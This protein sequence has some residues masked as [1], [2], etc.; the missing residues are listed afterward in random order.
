MSGQG[1]GAH[2]KLDGMLSHTRD[3]GPLASASAAPSCSARPS[4]WEGVRLPPS[5]EHPG[6]RGR[7]LTN[8]QAPGASFLTTRDTVSQAHSLSG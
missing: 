8:A 6:G 1:T 3:P 2:G 5:T 4:P 7:P